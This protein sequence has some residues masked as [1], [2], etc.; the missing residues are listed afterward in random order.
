MITRRRKTGWIAGVCVAAAAALAG[1]G[2][3]GSSG[4]V[5]SK[6]S[7]DGTVYAPSGEFAARP[8]SWQWAQA[9][10]LVARADAL[11]G[12]AGVITPEEVSLSRLD[13]VAAAHGCPP[14]IGCTQLITST[15][16]DSSGKYQISND[17]LADLDTG[18]LIVHVGSDALFTLTRAFVYSHSTDIDA[19]SE[20]LVRLVLHRLTQAPTVPLNTFTAE[21]LQSLAMRAQILTQDLSGDSVADVNANVYNRLA[22]SATMQKLMDDITGVPVTP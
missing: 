12:M 22:T 17:A 4:V 2:A 6:P 16:T 1:C 18:R 15:R 7:V 3:D 21:A 11:Q 8:R 9:L 5:I 19:N 14:Q 20:A 13:P 10:T